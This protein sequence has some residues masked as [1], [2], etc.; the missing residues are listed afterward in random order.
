MDVITLMKPLTEG[1][2]RAINFFN[3]R[4]LSGEDLTQ[5]Q[6]A[7]HEARLR[8]G[9]AIGE[10][11]VFGLEVVE[12]QGVS[13]KTAP[14]VT[15]AAGLAVNRAGQ[16]LRLATNTNV[17][18]VRPGNGSVSGAAGAVF[19][20]CKPPQSGVYIA[21][22]GVYL[23]TMAPVITSEGRAPVTGLGNTAASCNTQY[24]VEGV[25]F[26]LLQLDLSSS[27]L[28][29]PRLRNLV[30]YKCFGIEALGLFARNPFGP[31]S[32]QYGLLDTLRTQQ[33]KDDEIP[34]AL[35]YWTASDGIR[36]I[37]RWAVR[38]RITQSDANAQWRM[39]S[40]DRRVS[41]AEAVFQQFEEQIQD[42]RG[43]ESNL[44]VLVAKDRFRYL[45]P[46]GFLPL[47]ASGNL[48]PIKN[49]SASVGFTPQTFFG[50]QASRE[51]ALLDAALLRSLFSE[52]IQ[53]EPIDLNDSQRIQ[54]YLIWENVQAVESGAVSQ[55]TLV[56]ASPMLPYYGAA[57]FG[58][59]KWDRSRVASAVI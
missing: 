5:E 25:R 24:T 9:R 19:A 8:L 32:P 11:V 53:H 38:R 1:G 56:F 4:L 13:T 58:Y 54:L 41:E 57:R 31:V 45:P 17:S 44:D 28:S 35:I 39:L 6:A 15:V 33:L 12:T 27:E 34:L 49:S 21:G 10:G 29:D 52:G 14:V 16:P 26:R 48:V 37:D 46:V 23:L 55:L 51:V 22:A 7:N 18:L 3:G 40:S 47:K 50:Q 59:S 42:I 30:A 43:A 2:I 20:E 36:F